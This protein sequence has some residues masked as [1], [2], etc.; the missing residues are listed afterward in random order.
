M[1]SYKVYG[2]RNGRRTLLA[3][4]QSEESAR[5]QATIPHVLSRWDAVTIERHGMR[6][7]YFQHGFTPKDAR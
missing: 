6:V 5:E 4:C 2:W 7:A 1:N 3:S